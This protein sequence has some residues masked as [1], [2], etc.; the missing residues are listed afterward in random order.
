MRRRGALRRLV[1]R[2]GSPGAETARGGRP[3]RV[4]HL[5]GL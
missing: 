4:T 1:V 5:R 3:G 2:G